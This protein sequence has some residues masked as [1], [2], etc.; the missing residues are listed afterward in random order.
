MKLTANTT[1]FTPTADYLGLVRRFPLRPIR[2]AVE[3]RTA[4]TII[5]ELMARGKNLSDGEGDYIEAIT[6]FIAEWERGNLLESLGHASP[7]ETLLH[8][9]ESRG[10]TPADLGDIIGSRSAATMLLKGQREMSK[11][12]IRAIAEHFGVS[13]AVFL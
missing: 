12:H 5:D 13:P 1:R 6:R 11:A 2:S 7:R 8:L 4:L 9:M 3:H 10:M